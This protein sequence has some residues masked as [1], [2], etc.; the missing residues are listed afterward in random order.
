VKSLAENPEFRLSQITTDNMKELYGLSDNIPDPFFSGIP[1]Q[2]EE[3]YTKLS[4]LKGSGGNASIETNDYRVA[5]R[6]LGL[7]N[8]YEDWTEQD[9]VTAG[10]D[11]KAGKFN[12]KLSELSQ[13]TDIEYQPDQVTG[14]SP[15]E[16]KALTPEYSSRAVSYISSYPVDSE[17]ILSRLPIVEEGTEMSGKE[18]FINLTPETQKLAAYL[19]PT[20]GGNLQITSSYRS[21]NHPIEKAKTEPGLHSKGTKFDL[22][23]VVNNANLQKSYCLHSCM[24]LIN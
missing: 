14:V 11:T 5:S 9:K 21:E 20:W 4:D 24:D 12:I 17:D 19:S 3:S 10:L 7:P 13:P 23:S 2:S 6:L 22:Q 15:F 1:N 18:A 16:A 8:E